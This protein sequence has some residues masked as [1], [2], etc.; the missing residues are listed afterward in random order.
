[1]TLAT[2]IGPRIA[3]A[4]MIVFAAVSSVDA[5][6]VSD[7]PGINSEVGRFYIPNAVQQGDRVLEPGDELLRQPILWG[8]AARIGQEVKIST[9]EGDVSIPA[10]TVLPAVSVSDWRNDPESAVIV[11]CT[12]VPNLKQKGGGLMGT[13]GYALIR[14]LEDGR[15]CLADQN[16]DGVAEHGF[17]LDDGVPADRLPHAINPVALNVGEMVEAGSGDYVSIVVRKASRPS[18]HIVIYQNGK[19]MDFDSIK[20]TSGTVPRVQTVNKDATY[21]LSYEIYGARFEIRSF[22][23]ATGKMTIA[24]KPSVSGPMPIP[25][26]IRYRY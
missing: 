3:C 22:D 13:I 6:E 25:S 14:S 16:Y 24:S 12:N 1:M 15:K 8:I 4:L 23:P 17:L 20:T 26:E 5:A 11:Y 10:G 19:R 9:S 7:K 18:F 2:D 21:P